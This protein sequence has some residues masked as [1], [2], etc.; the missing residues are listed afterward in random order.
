MK[1]EITQEK[2]TFTIRIPGPHGSRFIAGIP[3]RKEARSIGAQINHLLRMRFVALP[4]TGYC[5]A[6]VLGENSKYHQSSYHFPLHRFTDRKPRAV[7]GTMIWDNELN[8]EL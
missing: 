6:A 7:E 8:Q 3:S 4:D 2:E 5:R 1:T